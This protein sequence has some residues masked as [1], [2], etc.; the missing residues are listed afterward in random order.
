MN[1]KSEV[2]LIADLKKCSALEKKKD[3][4]P[5][6]LDFKKRTLETLNNIIKAKVFI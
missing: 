6:L 3:H 4:D 1:A 5:K 2:E